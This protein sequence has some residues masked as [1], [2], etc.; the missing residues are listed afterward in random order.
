M[1]SSKHSLDDKGSAVDVLS[2]ADEAGRDYPDKAPYADEEFGGTEERIRIERK[3]LWKL[4]CRMSIMIVIY[5]LNYVRETA[6][7]PSL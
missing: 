4:D 2:S 6:F 1:A 5:I 7:H 3:L